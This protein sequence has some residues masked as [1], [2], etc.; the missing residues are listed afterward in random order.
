MNLDWEQ[1][2]LELFDG[3]LEQLMAYYPDNF[4]YEDTVLGIRI[5][6]D[7]EKLRA[8]FATFD[9]ADEHASKHFFN[10]TRYHGD[11]SGGCVEWTWRIDHKTDFLGLPS[12]GKTTTVTGMTIH[13][14]L[15]G[16]I[17]LERSVWDSG[18]LMRQLGMQAPDAVL[19]L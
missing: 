12:A 17:I 19:A 4:E 15:D 8:L 5:D 6:N 3:G 10:A 1:R 16:K 13:K 11:E 7:R 9:N 18:S 2:W 14:F